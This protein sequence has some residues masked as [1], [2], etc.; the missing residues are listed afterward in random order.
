[1]CFCERQM[2]PQGVVRQVWKWY[3]FATRKNQWH[4]MKEAQEVSGNDDW[5]QFYTWW[6]MLAPHRGFWYR[7]ECKQKPRELM[8]TSEIWERKTS[9]LAKGEADITL[10]LWHQVGA[11]D[12]WKPEL[13]FG[14]RCSISYWLGLLVAHT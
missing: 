2:K 6:R 8:T 5:V 4:W 13:S 7:F 10:T 1:M 12:N 9:L 11:V 14:P 3:G